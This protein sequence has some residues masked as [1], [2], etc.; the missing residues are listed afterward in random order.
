MAMLFYLPRLFVYHTE[1]KENKE[2]TQVV[3]IQEEKLYI[4]I[5]NPALIA[6]LASGGAMIWL[7]TG[8]F[9]CNWFYIKLGC[10]F[11]LMLYH[12][13]LRIF[14]EKLKKENCYRSGKFFRFYNE[15]P[16]ILMIIIVFMVVV[17]PF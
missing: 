7:N 11:L 9:K 6:S 17:K 16:T 8:L 1:H 4:Y 14:K 15:I 3:K 13:S 2:F 10:V 12:F 5:G